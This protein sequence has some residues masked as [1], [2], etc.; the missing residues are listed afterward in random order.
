MSELKKQEQNEKEIS[1]GCTVYAHIN[2]ANKKIY[3]GQTFQEPEK[4]WRNGTGYKSSPYFWNA[5]Q[6]Y[7]WDG[8]EHIIIFN[9]LSVDEANIFEAELIKK[10]KTTIP[11]YG[12]NLRDGGKNGKVPISIRRKI[13]KTLREKFN[14]P[15]YKERFRA[16]S[17][18]SK[19][20][21]YGKP[22]SEKT[23]NRLSEIAKNRF[24]NIE[25]HPRYKATLS[26]ETKEKIRAA[27][28]D[29]RITEE[30]TIKKL[31]NS[32]NVRKICLV[33][34]DLSIYKIFNTKVEAENYINKKIKIS[35]P[36]NL[37]YVSDDVILL[38]LEVYDELIKDNDFLSLVKNKGY[39]PKYNAKKVICLNDLSI[40]DNIALASKVKNISSA[41]ISMCCS[42]TRGCAGADKLLGKLIWEYYDENKKY[43]ITT[44]SGIRAKQCKC[45]T[46]GESFLSAQLASDKY[47][48][49][50]YSISLAC[51]KNQNTKGGNTYFKKLSWCYI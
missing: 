45:I 40:Y 1:N 51:R 29:H 17:T 37:Y 25:N 7:G 14:S 13:S 27:N 11:N 18:G 4:R 39:K 33:K 22:H 10:Y 41:L 31:E 23:R 8:F 34:S 48:I 21:H 30:Q 20:S 35:F 16:N 24:I 49:P 42:G 46:T 19:N 2:K 26:K 47:D 43:E 6:K 50:K 38:Y 28:L 9:N 15:Y 12:Y 36:S 3:I 44:Y 5:I 32:K